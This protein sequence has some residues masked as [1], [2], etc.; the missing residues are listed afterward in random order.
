MACSASISMSCSSCGSMVQQKA[1][2]KRV[3]LVETMQTRRACKKCRLPWL[4]SNLPVQIHPLRADAPRFTREGSSS[5]RGCGR[6]GWVSVNVSVKRGGK[7][8][9][10]GN[11]G[12]NFEVNLT[13][14]EGDG[15]HRGHGRCGCILSRCFSRCTA[16]RVLCDGEKKSG[17][18]IEGRSLKVTG[19][20][21]RRTCTQS[22]RFV[23]IAT[24][25]PPW[26]MNRR[27]DT[28]TQPPHV[29]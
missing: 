11:D 8:E 6:C 12:V 9:T 21:D 17:K 3:R 19:I 13:G 29:H 27:G 24:S 4:P 16:F 15:K 28:S 1:L 26:P 10:R 14:K 23:G 25:S 22:T 7:G 5:K 2:L 18:R 20:S